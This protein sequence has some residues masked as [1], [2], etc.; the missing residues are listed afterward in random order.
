MGHSLLIPTLKEWA[1]SRTQAQS[2]QCFPTL[3]TWKHKE[4]TQSLRTYPQETAGSQGD[5]GTRRDSLSQHV[6]WV[7]RHGPSVE[8]LQFQSQNGKRSP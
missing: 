1:K 7:N 3:F 5:A 2:E 4:K 8:Q 6:Y